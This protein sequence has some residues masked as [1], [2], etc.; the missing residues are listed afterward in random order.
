M[1][2]SE[3]RARG[4]P[5]SPWGWF[6]R[7]TLQNA[8]PQTWVDNCS[9]VCLGLG[10]GM[11]WALWA[12]RVEHPPTAWGSRVDQRHFLSR[13]YMSVTFIQTFNR[14]VERHWIGAKGKGRH[15]LCL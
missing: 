13:K 6:S 15:E 1:M 7:E 5:V 4:E 3:A 8:C 9:V 10:E 11:H 2:G 12:G 14:C